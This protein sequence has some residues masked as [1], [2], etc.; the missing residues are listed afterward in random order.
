MTDIIEFKH[1][2]EIL[3]KRGKSRAWLFKT[4]KSELIGE[5]VAVREILKTRPWDPVMSTWLWDLSEVVVDRV[6]SDVI[7]TEAERFLSRGI[8]YQHKAPVVDILH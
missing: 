6:E 8:S 2:Q 7:K 5:F 1:Y 4:S 3:K